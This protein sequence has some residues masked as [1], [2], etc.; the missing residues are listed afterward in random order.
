[1]K[2]TCLTFLFALTILITVACSNNNGN[3]INDLDI[4]LDS[5][6]KNVSPSFSPEPISTPQY[7]PIEYIEINT[8][9]KWNDFAESYNS[10]RY[11][12]SEHIIIEINDVLDFKDMEFTPLLDGFSGK[13]IGQHTLSEDERHEWIKLRK[14]W[15]QD[16]SGTFVN[17]SSFSE[18]YNKTSKSMFGNTRKLEMEN[19]GFANIYLNNTNCLITENTENLKIKNV[20]VCNCLLPNGKAIISVNAGEI[21]IE[22]F[23]AES[24]F[25]TGYEYMAGLVTFVE[26]D[27]KFNDVFMCRC[28]LILSPDNGGSGLWGAGIGVLAK[29]IIGEASFE[30]IDIYACTTTSLYTD[31]LVGSVGSLGMCRT[32]SLEFCSFINYTP[33]SAD[34]NSGLITSVGENRF[35]KTSIIEENVL[36]KDCIIGGEYDSEDFLSRGYSTENCIFVSSKENTPQ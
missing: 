19:V 6:T 1:M 14:K 16:Y 9:T 20:S 27:A 32:I 17:I 33:M 34:F 36:I 13:I 2:K 24:C 26:G 10:E 3:I 5:P 15:P 8:V 7:E 18:P 11:K 30:N 35:M 22:N 31:A 12:Y 23:I 4:T 29:S 21:S 28:S 25:L